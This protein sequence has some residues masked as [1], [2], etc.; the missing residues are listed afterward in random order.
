[1]VDGD[2]LY[3][4][5]ETQ[6]QG[7]RQGQGQGSEENTKRGLV[8][9]D[10][11]SGLIASAASS[12]GILNIDT[13]TKCP[14]EHSGSPSAAAATADADAPRDSRVC[15]PSDNRDPLAQEIQIERD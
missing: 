10:E 12:R 9:S 14:D 15:G 5:G 6:K 4:P 2:A 7:Q 8:H 11:S 3:R 13:S 1:M